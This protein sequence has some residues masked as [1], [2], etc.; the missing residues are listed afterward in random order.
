VSMNYILS[1]SESVHND[2]KKNEGLVI[3]DKSDLRKKWPKVL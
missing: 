3:M 2:Q 1:K